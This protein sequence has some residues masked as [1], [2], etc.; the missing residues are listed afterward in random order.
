MNEV[1]TTLHN[2]QEQKISLEKSL[3]SYRVLS[4]PA[5]MSWR[6]QAMEKFSNP[7]L[8]K[9]SEA[10]KQLFE[11]RLKNCPVTLGRVKLPGGET[12]K[13]SNLYELVNLLSDPSN[14]IPYS[15]K[16]TRQL[17]FSTSNG[18][19]PSENYAYTWWN[20]FQVM[21]MDIKDSK[22]A[23]ELKKHI[24]NKLH[25]CNWFLGVTLSASGEGLHVYT[26]IAIPEDFE[27]NLQ[28]MRLLY[29]AN[30]RHKYSFLYIAC[31]D[32]LE[33]L[34]KTKEDLVKWIDL[35]MHKPAQGAFV[36]Y[37]KNAMISTNFF[38]DFIYICFDNVEDLGHPEIDWI[39]HPELKELFGC[40]EWNEDSKNDTPEI[41]VLEKDVDEKAI[42]NKVHYKHHERWRLANTLTNLYGKTDGYRYLRAIVSNKVRSQE[43]KADIETAWRHKKPI[44]IWAVTR[45]N[46]N[47]GF[48]IKLDIEDQEVKEADLMDIMRS[49]PNP[50]NIRPSKN[51]HTFNITKDQYLTDILDDLIKK[52]GKITLI[53]A[54]PGLGKTEMVKT[55]VKKGKKVMMILPFTSIIKSKVESNKGWYY[56]YGGRKPKLD[57]ENGLALTV[58]KFSRLNP[59]DIK[60]AGFDY[61]F[62]DESHLLFMSEYRP[63]MSKVIEMIRNSEV[64]I[65]LMSGT[66]TGELIF[67]PDITHLHVIRAEERKKEL[68][69]NLVN[70]A[71]MQLLYM[72]KAMAKDIADG[73]RILYPSNEGTLHSKRVKA[74]I[75]YFLKLDHAWF[76]DVK[77]EY[78]K[79]SNLGDSFMDSVNFKKTIK[80][81]QV[82]M[83]TTYMGC[84]VDIEDKYNFKIYFGD[85]V[86][87]A[88]CDQWCNRLRRRDLLVKMFISKNDADGN[89]R[90]IKQW[91]RMNFNLDPEEV[92][93][94]HSTL[95]ICNSMIERNPIEYKY[96]P[97]VQAIIKE[98]RYIVYDDI[99]SKYYVDEIAYKTVMFE[100][101]YR[102]FHQQLPVFMKGMQ[103]YGYDFHAYEWPDVIVEGSEVFRQVKDMIKN[104]SD[105]HIQL[106]TTYVEE[107]LNNIK[108]SSLADFEQVLAGHYEIKKG[109][110]W[111]LDKSGTCYIVKNAEVFDKVIPVFLSMTK[112]FEIN[113]VRK[114]FEHCRNS[115][116]RYNFAA[117]NRI[118]TLIN[119]KESDEGGRLDIPIKKF[120]DDVYEF[121][122]KY[123]DQ[124]IHKNEL[125]QW[126]ENY[127][128]DY[129]RQESTLEIIIERSEYMMKR[130]VD[131]F[132]KLFKVF[133]NNSR[134]DRSGTMTME[135]V[136]LLWE[137][138]RG[139]SEE[140]KMGFETY[141]ME[142]FMNALEETKVIETEQ[143][144]SIED[145]E[146]P[147]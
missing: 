58:D 29:L 105:E 42:Q 8:S 15:K 77:L 85:L 86:T 52:S 120:M 1:I 114:I 18:K 21:D 131:R 40:L 106:N 61:I 2:E 24:F 112:R 138:R 119:I 95:R 111:G 89:P 25:K 37:D 94:L 60:L 81:T 5:S 103:C 63:V 70:S 91:H 87:A 64:P 96:N 99:S 47:H 113:T 137:K 11:K 101:K 39:T 116:G 142:D 65:V 75:S 19:R 147:F 55:L 43:L 127:A 51:Y 110:E 59:I 50:N 122:E 93:A 73:Y 4:A 90:N 22:T 34:G 92:K 38:E 100:K 82:V 123:K 20:G 134:P 146:V 17:V 56:S 36:P 9:C 80:D 83:C 98:N 57:V 88:E 13:S 102:D 30:F 46:N 28:K 128:I 10:E 16:L 97:L 72:C 143:V 44:D 32:A 12:G 104:A 53:E 54:G 126:I 68:E 7:L 141:L 108:N 121:T 125:K 124:R 74:G 76:D 109:N 31:M 66:P 35:S 79:K 71:N 118:R 117:I 48:S 33:G 135:R 130:L 115:S 45:L 129:A 144:E 49:I 41:S 27:D 67:F 136:E 84:G 69:V 145:I 133:V 78:Y 26:K 62:L 132:T 14:N 6:A 139:Y 140:T 23:K 107:L 3:N